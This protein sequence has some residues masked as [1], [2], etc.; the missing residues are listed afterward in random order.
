MALEPEQPAVSPD[1]A[2]PRALANTQSARQ[3]AILLAVLLLS[4][5]VAIAFGF[6]WFESAA[7]T[8]LFAGV[9]A[10]SIAYHILDGAI[11]ASFKT[12][13]LQLGGAAAILVGVMFAL[14]A[15]LKD[16]SERRAARSR[17]IDE[18]VEPFAKRLRDK[19][20][21][22]ARRDARIAQLQQGSRPAGGCGAT[23]GDDE[24]AARIADLDPTSPLG[25]RLRRIAREERGPWERS[26]M[27]VQIS[28]TE[29]KI[30]EDRRSEP[31]FRAC[32]SNER[33]AGS[34]IMFALTDPALSAEG[35]RVTARFAGR[36][37][38][39]ECEGSNA[40]RVQLSCAS[41]LRMIPSG[42]AGCTASGVIRWKA[43]FKG[44]TR[45]AASGEIVSD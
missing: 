16:E 20:I 19:D 40:D 42:V 15:P 13:M 25:D 21:E 24:I 2:T 35:E 18:A 30:E 26:S 14:L 41:A 33:A 28:F 12:P 1:A 27:P 31:V 39:N 44:S 45:Y 3:I 34:R 6:G 29:L 4:A 5:A 23:C 32:R 22:I 8:A 37:G 10:A 36:I 43:G 9:L 11:G 7:I 38:D 17:A